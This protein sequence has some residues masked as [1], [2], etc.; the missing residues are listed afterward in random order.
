MLNNYLKIAWRNIVNSRFYSL[1]NIVG[2]SAGLAFTLIIGAYIWSEL[3]VNKHLKNADR[4][5]II[6]SKWKHPNQGVELTTPGP[7][8]KQLKENYPDLVANYHRWDGIG[9]NVSKGNKSFREGLQIC[10]STMLDIYGFRLL[11]GNAATAFENPYTLI[12]SA[13]KAIKYFGKTNV[14]GETLTIENFSG[15]K[16]DFMITGILEM[17]AK[18]SVTY[19]ND[20]NNSQ[21]YISSKNLAYFGRNMEWFNRYIVGYIE[22]RKGIRPEDLEKP[23]EQLIKQHAPPQISENMTP[24]L[25]SL[26]DYYLKSNNALVEKMIYA[27]SLIAFFIMLMAGINFVNM[28]VSRSVTR[29]KEIGIRKALGGIKKQ[30]I[31]QYLTES[32][33]LVFVATLLALLVYCVTRSLF[34]NVLGKD[35]PPLTAFPAY[36]ALYPVALV[37]IVGL[38]A[39]IY[40]AMILSSMRSVDALKGK[41]ATVKDKIWLRKSLVACQFGIAAVVFIGAIIVSQQIDLFFSKELGYNKDFILTAPVPRDWTPEGVKKMETVRSRFAAMPHVINATLSYEAPDGNNSGGVALY[42]FGEDSA[43]AIPSQLLMTDEYYASTYNI[44]MAAGEFFSA[45]GTFTDLSKL[46]INEAHARALGW[47]NPQ[48]AIGRQVTFQAGGGMIS[49]I[50]GVTKDFHFESM[51]VAIQPVT[52][53]HV[54]LTNTFRIFSFKVK[55]GN[56]DNT[57]A[58][59][60][61][62]WSAL[63]PGAPFEYTFMDDNL[64]KLYKTELQLKKAGY[65]A[66]I[67]ASIIVLLGVFG[68]ISLSIHKRTREIG[69]RK[70]LGS[71]VGGIIGLFLKDFML[72]IL[73]AGIVSC[74]VSYIIMHHWLNSYAY[75]I[76]I[77]AQPFIISMA[78]LSGVTALLI[79]IQTIQAA[80]ANPVK[81]LRTE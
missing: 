72:L 2:L 63:M 47:Q 24:Y 31:I 41:L 36:F 60:Q 46:V 5:Y 16:H 77:N 61:K 74:P 71:S 37:C 29:L 11:H 58:A 8:A 52:F 28:A 32:T 7:L 14:V 20:E 12:I 69:I 80:S 25:V 23:M 57:I 79:W 3:Q 35:I 38:L 66:T 34:S 4:Q 65:T 51:Q 1:V 42:K 19:L 22:L 75:R 26:K 49:T 54:D 30:L 21:F 45:P 40:P 13:G 76:D 53:L 48:D 78:L 44:P 68:L 10:D 55:P 15:L 9:S 18:N 27:L 67:L 17:P 50:V 43:T 6:Q 56:L 70:V 39:G 33:I 81:S 64:A 59:L 73:V 62:Q